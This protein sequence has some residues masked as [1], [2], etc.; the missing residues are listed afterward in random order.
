MKKRDEK[1]IKI[2]ITIMRLNFL[3]RKVLAS[4]IDKKLG[5]FLNKT[6]IFWII[7]IVVFYKNKIINAMT[8]V[9]KSPILLVILNNIRLD[10]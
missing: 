9:L 7:V 5:F 10:I 6:M 8:D 1:K 2:E 4:K 3:K